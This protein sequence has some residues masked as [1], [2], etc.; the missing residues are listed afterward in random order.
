MYTYN[1]VENKR[2]CNCNDNLN[3]S[4]SIYPN[5]SHEIKYAYEIIAFDLYYSSLPCN[6]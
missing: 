5:S 3:K 6:S 1:T 2:Q 4:S